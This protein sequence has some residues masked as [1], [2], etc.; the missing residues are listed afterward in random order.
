MARKQ[1]KTSKAIAAINRRADSLRKLYGENSAEYGEFTARMSQYDLSFNEKTGSIHIRDTKENRAAYRQLNAWAR[2]IRKTPIQIEQRKA[3]K[4]DAERRANDEFFGDTDYTDND[5]IANR[6]VYNKWLET[7][8]D[9]FDSCYELA[10][11]EGYDGEARLERAKVLDDYSD[12]YARVWNG[13]YKSGVFK[14]YEQNRQD[15]NAQADAQRTNVEIDDESGEAL[16]NPDFYYL[17]N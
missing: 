11:L 13:F 2:E 10:G 16:T 17:D 3:A 8:N 5:E 12:E 9:Y 6:E 7:C 15:Y 14:E 1:T 4:K